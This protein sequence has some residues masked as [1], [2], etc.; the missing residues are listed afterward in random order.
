MMNLAQ[1]KDDDDQERVRD[2]C[3]KSMQ[4]GGVCFCECDWVIAC[5]IACLIRQRIRANNSD[6][7]LHFLVFVFV[8]SFPFLFP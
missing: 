3:N 5:L 6:T 4:G 8:F 2:E 7:R 1:I